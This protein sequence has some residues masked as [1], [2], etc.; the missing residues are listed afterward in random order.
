[1]VRTGPI[2]RKT[3]CR[4]SGSIGALQA[5]PGR[6]MQS[7]AESSYDAWIKG[8]RPDE[9][10]PNTGISYYTM[11]NVIGFLLDARIRAA[12][13]NAKSL[14]DAMR[15]AYQR[16]G[17]AIGF[18]PKDFRDCVG[19]VAGP[20]VAEWL[21]KAE[22]QTAD[23]D[24]V[25]ELAHLGLRFR[26]GARPSSSSNTMEKPA[27]GWL[28]AQTRVNGASV[29]VSGVQ[30]ETPAYEAGL[31][32]DDEIVSIGDRRIGA[33]FWPRLGDYYRAGETVEFVV[34]RRGRMVKVPITFG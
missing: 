9:N 33:G 6:K 2:D 25:A 30:R 4:L 29:F 26:T 27:K 21:I 28:G 31:N 3:V 1:M 14:D 12:T 16:F 23:F 13:G 34:A 8:Y 10:S 24:Y 11:G 17:G 7:A 20:V 5:R 15:L 18:T 22:Y 19:E 32:V